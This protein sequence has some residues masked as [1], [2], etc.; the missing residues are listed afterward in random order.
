MD[1]TN[2][3]VIEKAIAHW[4]ALAIEQDRHIAEGITLCPQA[5]KSKADLYRRTAEALRIELRTGQPHCA[6][7][8]KPMSTRQFWR[9][10]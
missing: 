10:A 7:C 8:L 5:S 3:A 2:V 1:A 9:P 4:D 6:C